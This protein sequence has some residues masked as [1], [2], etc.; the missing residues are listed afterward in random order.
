MNLFYKIM[1]NTTIAGLDL[2]LADCIKT[3]DNNNFF[4]DEEKLALVSKANCFV[5]HELYVKR[6]KENKTVYDIFYSNLHIHVSMCE[7]EK[8]FSIRLKKEEDSWIFTTIQN[9]EVKDIDFSHPTNE[10]YEV[11]VWYEVP[12][13]DITKSIGYNYRNG[14][15]DKYLY[16]TVNRFIEEV[17]NIT[18]KSKF[19]EYYKQQ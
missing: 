16:Q 18:G 6:Q 10:T 9:G 15:W 1:V 14:T 8:I 17:K 7:S 2:K 3:L 11:Y 13:L 5:E 19:N 12:V 4:N